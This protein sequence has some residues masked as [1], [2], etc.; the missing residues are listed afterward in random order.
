MKMKKVISTILCACLIGSC[1][2]FAGC[3]D[4][5]KKDKEDDEIENV[6]DSDSDSE[7][8]SDSGSSSGDKDSS[9]D[10]IDTSKKSGQV[11]KAFVDS[12]DSTNDITKTA[13]DISSESV[14]GYNC[15]SMEVFEGFLNGF[16]ADI[17]GFNKGIVVSPAIGSI[18]YVSYIFETDDA[19]ALKKTLLDHADPRWNICTEADETLCEVHGDYVFFIMCP[20]D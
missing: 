13:E 4:S 8:E 9:T 12:I 20:A 18:P 14:T 5:D 7:S 10:D 6:D 11:Y 3:S 19:E 16:D 17:S 15:M 1:V 2:A